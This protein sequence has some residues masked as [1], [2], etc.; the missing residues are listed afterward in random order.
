MVGEG[1][2]VSTAQLRPFVVTDA[3]QS[4]IWRG[5]GHSRHNT[6]LN[7]RT[8]HMSCVGK[9]SGKH[10]AGESILQWIKNM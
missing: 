4:V 9:P 3:P 5:M 8:A 10:T 6:A 7:H 1:I 2:A